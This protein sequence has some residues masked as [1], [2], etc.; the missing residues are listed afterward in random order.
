MYGRNFRENILYLSYKKDN[1]LTKNYPYTQQQICY[2]SVA[3][4]TTQF[5]LKLC[6]IIQEMCICSWNKFYDFL[7]HRNTFLNISKK[8]E[9]P[10]LGCTK[11]APS[12]EKTL[13][14]L[15][16]SCEVC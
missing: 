2:F 3:K 12:S 15:L 5:L 9:T 6:M 13:F 14:Y 11:S 10:V 8:L 1:F 7:K 16:H 4:N